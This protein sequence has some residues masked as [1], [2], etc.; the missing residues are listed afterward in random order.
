MYWDIQGPTCFKLGLMI[1]TIKLYT[2]ILVL[3]ALIFIQGN[4]G[5]RKG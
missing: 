4:R 1:D 5:A 3:V 2:L